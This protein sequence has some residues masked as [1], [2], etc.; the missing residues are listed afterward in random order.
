MGVD[1]DNDFSHSSDDG[2]LCSSSDY[3]P[4][5]SPLRKSSDRHHASES[6]SG[7]IDSLDEIMGD[8]KRVRRPRPSGTE[9]PTSKALRRK[10]VSQAHKLSHVPPRQTLDEESDSSIDEDAPLGDQR[11]KLVNKPKHKRPRNM[12]NHERYEESSGGSRQKNRKKMRV[13]DDVASDDGSDTEDSMRIDGGAEASDYDAMS[14]S[15]QFG[16]EDPDIDDFEESTATNLARRRMQSRLLDHYSVKAPTCNDSKKHPWSTSEENRPRR[17][18]EDK[19]SSGGRGL[20]NSVLGVKNKERHG[21]SGARKHRQSR[22]HRIHGGASSRGNGTR[23]ACDGGNRRNVGGSRGRRGSN[24]SEVYVAAP[25]VD[26]TVEDTAVNMIPSPVWRVQR[27]HSILSSSWTNGS[28]PL[29]V[30]S[31]SVCSGASAYNYASCHEEDWSDSA[32]MRIERTF[33]RYGTLEPLAEEEV[34]AEATATAVVHSETTRAAVLA[35]RLPSDGRPLIRALADRL[36]ARIRLSMVAAAL[37]RGRNNNSSATSDWMTAAAQIKTSLVDAPAFED[38]LWCSAFAATAPSPLTN[39]RVDLVHAIGTILAGAEA[40]RRALCAAT[41][42]RYKDSLASQARTS[43]VVPGCSGFFGLL[44]SDPWHAERVIVPSTARH[45]DNASETPWGEAAEDPLVLLHCFALD[46]LRPP[47]AEIAAAQA[48]VTAGVAL[49]SPSSKNAQI[50][51]EASRAHLSCL[52]KLLIAA[53]P[54]VDSI[55][56][57]PAAGVSP[58]LVKDDPTLTKLWDCAAVAAHALE[59]QDIIRANNHNE[60]SLPKIRA[61][62]MTS[63]LPAPDM[64]KVASWQNGSFWGFLVD[65]FIDCYAHR[66]M[67]HVK[68]FLSRSPWPEAL[69]PSQATAAGVGQSSG[70]TSSVAGSGASHGLYVG[71]SSRS[72]LLTEITAHRQSP[73]PL[74]SAALRLA[75]AH[76]KSC[77][78]SSSNNLVTTCGRSIVPAQPPFQYCSAPLLSFRTPFQPNSLWGASALIGP[79]LAASP[80]ALVHSSTISS[81]LA[82]SKAKSRSSS[83]HAG[84]NSSSSSVYWAKQSMAWVRCAHPLKRTGPKVHAQCVEIVNC[85]GALT[86][87]GCPA[88]GTLA[89]STSAKLKSTRAPGTSNNSAAAAAAAA[90]A[91]STSSNDATTEREVAAVTSEHALAQLWAAGLRVNAHALLVRGR[92]RKFTT[93]SVT[94]N[95]ASSGGNDNGL[96]ADDGVDS[97]EDIAEDSSDSEDDEIEA[98]RKA[99]LIWSMT[100]GAR[101]ATSFAK[102]Q[103]P[104][105]GASTLSASASSSSSSSS[106]VSTSSSSSS[107]SSLA[108]GDKDRLTAHA[109]HFYTAVAFAASSADLSSA[110]PTSPCPSPTTIASPGQGSSRKSVAEYLSAVD[111]LLEVSAAAL[112]PL[113]CAW[114]SSMTSHVT[115]TTKS[116]GASDE[117]TASYPGLAIALGALPLDPGLRQPLSCSVAEATA[118]SHL[119][120]TTSHVSNSS[121]SDSSNSAS[122]TAGLGT[123]HD[124]VLHLSG[125][126]A[127]A[128]A[129]VTSLCRLTCRNLAMGAGLGRKRLAG[130]LF[131]DFERLEVAMADKD[132]LA[133]EDS[134]SKNYSSSQH[135]GRNRQ[136]VRSGAQVG[137][138]HA[139]SHAAAAWTVAAASEGLLGDLGSDAKAADVAA[140]FVLRS[141]R[142]QTVTAPLASPTS[143]TEA[144]A[145]SSS[146]GVSDRRNSSGGGVS[147]SWSEAESKVYACATAANATLATGVL[148]LMHFGKVSDDSECAKRNHSQMSASSSLAP[149]SSSLSTAPSPGAVAVS[150]K[151]SAHF[152]TA[153]H[154]LVDAVNSTIRLHSCPD[155]CFAASA[156]QKQLQAEVF[157]AAVSLASVGATSALLVLKTASQECVLTWRAALVPAA[158][159]FLELAIRPDVLSKAP[160]HGSDF[161][162][163]CLKVVAACA[164][165]CTQSHGP[166]DS[167]ATQTLQRAAALETQQALHLSVPPPPVVPSHS[168]TYTLSSVE[169]S[170]LAAYAA[171]ANKQLP[172]LRRL[173]QMAWTPAGLD[174]TALQLPSTQA[175][176]AATVQN[177]G[178]VATTAASVAKASAVSLKPPAQLSN[179]QLQPRVLPPSNAPQISYQQKP[180]QP[181]RRSRGVFGAQTT[182]VNA[183]VRKGENSGRGKFIPKAPVAASEL[184]TGLQRAPATGGLSAAFPDLAR[185]ETLASAATAS[186]AHQLPTHDNN[187][188]TSNS[189]MPGNGRAMAPPRPPGFRAGAG[190]SISRTSSSGSN[191]RSNNTRSSSNTASSSSSS[192]PQAVSQVNRVPA[193]MVDQWTEVIRQRRQAELSAVS[194]CAVEL[195][196]VF[197]ALVAAHLHVA[198]AARTTSGAPTNAEA[199]KAFGAVCDDIAALRPFSSHRNNTAGLGSGSGSAEVSAWVRARLA[200]PTWASLLAERYRPI[201]R[202]AFSPSPPLP[203]LQAPPSTAA[204]AVPT[205]AW[206]LLSIWLCA[207]TELRT[208]LAPKIAAMLDSPRHLRA[209]I[210]ADQ[211]TTAAA[212]QAALMVALGGK[213]TSSTAAKRKVPN[214]TFNNNP[215]VL[216][217]RDVGI[218]DANKAASAVLLRDLPHLT[219]LVLELLRAGPSRSS[220]ASGTSDAQAIEREVA[221]EVHGTLLLVRAAQ[222]PP[223]PGSGSSSSSNGASMVAQRFSA[224]GV[225]RAALRNVDTAIAESRAL[226]ALPMSS[227]HL[228]S[229]SR[230]TVAFGGSGGRNSAAS[231]TLLRQNDWVPAFG[232][233]VHSGFALQAALLAAAAAAAPPPCSTSS[234]STA[235]FAHVAGPAA[236]PAR[237]MATSVILPR[238]LIPLLKAA[239]ADYWYAVARKLPN[240]GVNSASSAAATTTTTSTFGNS[241]TGIRISASTQSSSNNSAN[242]SSA[243]PGCGLAEVCALPPLRSDNPTSGDHKVRRLLI[244][245]GLGSSCCKDTEERNNLLTSFVS[246]LVQLNFSQGDAKAQLGVLLNAVVA[247]RA[248]DKSKRAEHR[249]HLAGS[250]SSGLG[251]S[252]SLDRTLVEEMPT[253]GLCF[254]LTGSSSSDTTA[255]GASNGDGTATSIAASLFPPT[256]ASSSRLRL[257]RQHARSLFAARLDDLIANACTQSFTS[258]SNAGDLQ[259]VELAALQSLVAELEKALAS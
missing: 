241:T 16:Y 186:S 188:Q 48:T 160:H 68:D 57:R 67:R 164:P 89:A 216:P 65:A 36:S 134:N 44:W 118:L 12:R 173:V 120:R 19:R 92:H 211:A 81:S 29:R 14:D 136:W 206:P 53:S 167:F 171:A 50:C 11:A 178:G 149:S 51:Q 240:Q 72:S 129:L 159:Q 121:S 195:L 193:A 23:R 244:V 79:L 238:Y 165:Q 143:N 197:A 251:R 208:R 227:P 168:T 7:S 228:S 42:T 77:S 66:A 144:R 1:T 103:E 226:A 130:Q 122:Q 150:S 246:L 196:E 236:H 30:G 154:A 119:P 115:G 125:P 191:S 243:Q 21:V 47:S 110:S 248:A 153:L 26:T 259:A 2:S 83:G 128:Q 237:L 39:F 232:R 217:D 80:L 151:L 146:N 82:S 253:L 201:V 95:K 204:T 239:T 207:I 37:V 70:S 112:A 162:K 247:E 102:M 106:S 105:Q 59:S 258:S 180:P 90:T 135:Y 215:N 202:G 33:R 252:E 41:S 99:R 190:S 20:H 185:P 158:F 63:V 145:G 35:K 166:L 157:A 97:E 250:N 156:A 127:A 140:A 177:R 49:W 18:A 17:R 69:I 54:K 4:V 152:A 141:A 200:G 225:F 10:K 13:Q 60:S 5:D 223:P 28:E 170:A 56:R 86:S 111:A 233:V 91:E 34:P 235:S 71:V 169:A 155:P 131:N 203:Q 163:L 175:Y 38:L 78:Q 256:A 55:R 221:T 198:A 249:S 183:P 184:P 209:S 15:L 142:C 234:S 73:G 85:L 24:K 123:A 75:Q 179:V 230:A 138:Q 9:S 6:D 114:P 45:E 255:V 213:T 133:A 139:L 84:N 31:T 181:V 212:A 222:S 224:E 62:S 174:L 104:N 245:R 74:W 93:A 8:R 147:R 189:G 137:T 3:A 46:W 192:I 22:R 229:S 98:P 107:S 182:S 210:A 172:A 199:V 242:R 113:P 148:A 109:I 27:V 124:E 132:S 205:E 25:P 218:G 194:Q 108:L 64:G 43:V 52:T 219:A 100:P 231:A 87:L 176:Q 254:A 257:L 94:G 214:E 220:A 161:L 58:A 76:A 101:T 96:V 187:A 116:A 32:L 40:G 61:A 88:V 117:S 126:R